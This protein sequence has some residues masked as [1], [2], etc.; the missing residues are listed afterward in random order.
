MTLPE[1]LALLRAAILHDFPGFVPG[2]LTVRSLDGHKMRLPFP[3][4]NGAPASILPGGRPLSP[5]EEAIVTYLTGKDWQTGQLIAEG[6]GHPRS[7]SLNAILSN[8]A[9]TPVLESNQRHGYRLR[10]ADSDTSAP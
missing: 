3:A 8:L 1:V 2:E 6:I 5:T 10:V 9:E 4:R 7:S